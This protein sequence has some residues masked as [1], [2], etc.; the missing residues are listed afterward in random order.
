[1]QDLGYSWDHQLLSESY[2]CVDPASVPM[3]GLGAAA[4]CSFDV[5]ALERERERYY[6]CSSQSGT[7]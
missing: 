1:M 5:Q 7:D 6:I 2:L 4:G 3:G